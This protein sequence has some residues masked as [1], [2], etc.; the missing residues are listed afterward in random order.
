LSGSRPF[1]R[2]WSHELGRTHRSCHVQCSPQLWGLRRRQFL[3]LAWSER[4]T[5]ISGGGWTTRA[6]LADAPGEV[7][8][9][10][11]YF[12]SARSE[13]LVR[14]EHAICH[15]ILHER[16]LVARVAA[17]S[18]AGAERALAAVASA[19]PEVDSTDREVSARFWWSAQHGPSGTRSDASFTAMDRDRGEELRRCDPRAAGGSLGLAAAAPGRGR[20]LLWH[21]D[22]GTG[23]TNAIRSQ[24]GE[25][26][27]WA[28]FQF[29]TDP[30]AFL[31]NPGVSA[32]DDWR[33]AAFPPDRA[34]G[35]MEDRGARG[36]R[37]VLSVSRLKF[38]A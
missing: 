28:E 37:R 30:E 26:R 20:L 13:V 22:P 12:H 16:S 7:L 23:K 29:V 8:G 10:A 9:G 21:G 36:R 27:F 18:A 35:S 17:A 31:S 6:E 33:T 1:G 4:L 2:P 14:V 5:T 25:W 34:G 3:R 11:E 32:G 24:L 19:L 38:V 15:L